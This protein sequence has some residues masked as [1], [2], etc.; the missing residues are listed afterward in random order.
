M[1]F[2]SRLDAKVREVM[3]PKERLVTVR[4]GA[5]KN[6]VRELLHKHRLEK[7]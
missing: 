6:E 3:T 2:E 4:E 7:S 1:R 5:D